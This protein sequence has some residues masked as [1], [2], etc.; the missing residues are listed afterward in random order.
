M[1]TVDA[2]QLIDPA[3]LYVSQEA[4]RRLC[5]AEWAW[6][7]FRRKSKLVTTKI[8]N[9]VYVKGSEIIAAVDRLSAQGASDAE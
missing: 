2:P 6:K 3:S 9:R 4:M 8:G 1:A 5:M 7:Q